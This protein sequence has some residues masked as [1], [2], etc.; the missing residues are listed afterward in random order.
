LIAGLLSSVQPVQLELVTFAY[1][2]Y[3]YLTYRLYVN[4]PKRRARTVARIVR[5][6]G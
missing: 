1:R 3:V 5:D 4:R 6:E 2:L